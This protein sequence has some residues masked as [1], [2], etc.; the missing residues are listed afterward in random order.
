MR[1]KVVR[2]LLPVWVLALVGCSY[3]TDLVSDHYIFPSDQRAPT[4]EVSSSSDGFTTRDG[5]RLVADIYQPEGVSKAP[6]ILVRIPF[7]DTFMNVIRSRVIARNWARRGYVVVIQGTRGRY[8]SE[9]S[10]YP[11]INERTDGIETLHWI[12]GQPWYDGRLAMWGGSAF[13][14]TQWAIADQTEPGPQA[15]FIQI[16]SSHFHEMFYPGGA[17]SLESALYWAIRSRG[18]R[19]RDVTSSSLEKGVAKLPLTEVDNEAIGD[20]DFFNDWLLHRGD[21]TYWRRIDG[22]ENAEQLRAPVLLMGG[23]FDPFLPSQLA[24]YARIKSHANGAIARE[25]RLIIGPWTHAG[26]A[27]VPGMMERVPYRL[28]S[29]LPSIPWFDYVLKVNKEPLKLP[30]VRLFVMGANRWRS[31]NEWPL[32]RTRYEAFHICSKTSAATASGDGTLGKAPCASA[33][34]Y[35]SYRYDPL[36][37]VP[38]AGGATLGERAGIQRQQGVEEREDVLVYSTPPLSG[39][40]EVTG[41]VHALLY[42]ATDAPSTDFTVKVVDVYPDGTA[43]NLSDGIVRRSYPKTSEETPVKIEVELWPTSNVFRKDHRI[44]VEISSS[45]FPRYDRNLNTGEFFATATRSSIA[46]QKVFHSDRYPSHIMLPVI[47]P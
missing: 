1:C 14:Q 34:K 6:T 7:S 42:V 3:T 47:D 27:A 41:P 31:E 17:F 2:N 8:H 33:L 44:R 35:S 15:F 9:G 4:Y 11:L 32:A 19:D 12:A 13:G 18:D 29:I 22:I 30:P 5:V 23:W 45:N 39:D 38:S 20:T 40:V 21:K 16:A 37:P 24:D 26:E 25:T 28:H 36:N 43:Y 10:F 46:H